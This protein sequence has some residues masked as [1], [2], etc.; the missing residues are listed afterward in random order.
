MNLKNPLAIILLNQPSAKAA[1]EPVP[2]LVMDLGTLLSTF[3]HS[4]ST[5]ATPKVVS[6]EAS[7]SS[8][9][10]SLVMDALNEFKRDNEV[11]HERLDKQDQTNQE[12]RNWMMKQEESASEIKN[13]LMALVSK[14][15]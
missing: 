3:V 13:P 11:I 9:P 10:T 7:S 6:A 15:S 5:V 8:D 1:P 2:T 12:I 4:D 14:K